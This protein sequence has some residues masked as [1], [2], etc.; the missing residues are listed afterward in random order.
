MNKFK[1]YLTE[2]TPCLFPPLGLGALGFTLIYGKATWWVSLLCFA[3][4]FFSRYFFSYTENPFFTPYTLLLSSPLLLLNYSSIA[5]FNIR[6]VALVLFIVIFAAAYAGKTGTFKWDLTDK[7]PIIIWLIAFLLFSLVSVILYMQGIG[8][9]GD[10]PHYLMISQSLINDADFDLMNNF[11]QKTYFDYLPVE[12]HFHGGEFFGKLLSFH[13]PGLAFLLAP[14]YWLYKLLGGFIPAALYF[15]LVAAL[16]NAFFALALFF[17]LKKTFPEQKITGLWLFFLL[18]FPLAF[19]SVHLFPELP[20]ATFMMMAYLAVFN[21]KKHYWLAGLGLALIPWF[22]V[23]Y[24]PPLL[25]LTLVILV[26]LFGPFKPFTWKTLFTKE[27]LANLFRFV[28]FPVLSLL[29]IILYSKTLY[30]S[31]S[32]TD[33]FPKENYWTVPW[34]LRLKVFLAYFLD[35]R[36]GLLFYC[37]L[38][39]LVLFGFKKKF[40]GKGVLLSIAGIYLFFHAFTTVRGAYSPAGRPL[41]FISWILIVLIAHIYFNMQEKGKWLVIGSRLLVGLSVFVS[42]WLYYYPLFV[43]QPVIAETVERASSF[44]MFWSTNDMELWNFFPSFLTTSVSPHVATWIWLGLLVLL[45]SFYYGKSLRLGWFKFVHNSWIGL[46]LFLCISFLYCYYPN[47]YLAKE[48]KF[49]NKIISFYNNSHNF[50]YHEDNNSF[51]IKGGNK[52]DIFIDR[53]LKLSNTLTL[54]FLNTDGC[55]VELYNGRKKLFASKGQKEESF[56]CDLQALSTFKIAN[57]VVSHLGFD[58]RLVGV[59]KNSGDE[60][61]T[62]FLWLTITR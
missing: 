43:Y 31:Y 55:A 45:L 29:L 37:P 15:R 20:A 16:F 44:N 25:V 6:L 36:D 46:I 59:K 17:V 38:F 56:T 58:T 12:L 23:K 22:H 51:R 7:K 39:F 19:H 1:S 53:N 47:V 13:L 8:L 62:V 24:I 9:S 57:K 35:Q 3:L 10:E 49:T 2:I 42:L 48:R 52:Y 40:T 11:H 34:M 50:Y 4:I 21:E 27:K 26:Q 28:V 14:F 30:G 18:V 32:P 41:M 54:H 5:D 33:V 61:P 60:E